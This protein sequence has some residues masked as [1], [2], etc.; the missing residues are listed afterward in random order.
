MSVTTIRTGRGR[1]VMLRKMFDTSVFAP[2]LKG[3]Q[4]MD[5]GTN[6]MH[7]PGTNN[8]DISLFKDFRLGSDERRYLQF[9]IET[10]NTFNH[11]QWS[12]YGRSAIFNSAGVLTNLPTEVGKGTGRFGFGAAG[13]AT[14]GTRTER[15]IQIAAR[16]YF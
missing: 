5:S 10:Y 14:G 2:A 4:G 13:T 6:Y 16:I 9:R 12:D 15:R 11:K 3:S 1:S 7:G 8:W